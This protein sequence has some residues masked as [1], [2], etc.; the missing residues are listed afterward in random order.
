MHLFLFS[1]LPVDSPHEMLM[2]FASPFIMLSVYYTG[3]LGHRLHHSGVHGTL[4]VG[5]KAVRDNL[6]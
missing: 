2:F 3:A 4:S 5:K 1:L 6:G